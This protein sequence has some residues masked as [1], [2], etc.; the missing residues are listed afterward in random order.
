MRDVNVSQKHG[1]GERDTI[2]RKGGREGRKEG[3]R[4]RR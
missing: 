2:G 1:P 4:R 3:R